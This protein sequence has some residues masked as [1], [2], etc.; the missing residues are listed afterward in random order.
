VLKFAK[1]KTAAE[2][3]NTYA[4]WIIKPVIYAV[5]LT[6]VRTVNV[7]ASFKIAQIAFALNAIRRMSIRQEAVILIANSL[8]VKRIRFAIAL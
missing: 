2:Q 8:H 1:T 7:N 5:S 3:I 4:Q 6:T